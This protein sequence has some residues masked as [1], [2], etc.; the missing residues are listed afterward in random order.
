MPPVRDVVHGGTLPEVL[1]G[2]EEARDTRAEVE[3]WCGETD[4][5]EC[6]RAL[7]SRECGL[8]RRADSRG[9]GGRSHERR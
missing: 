9:N 7:V 8:S 5:S 2:A 1:S 4:G 3:L 6:V